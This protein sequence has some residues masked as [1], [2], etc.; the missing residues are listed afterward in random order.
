M[1]SCGKIRP[2]PRVIETPSGLRAAIRVPGDRTTDAAAPGARLVEYRHRDRS[3]MSPLPL[4][5]CLAKPF[6]GRA[7]R[8]SSIPLRRVGAA[9]L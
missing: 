9:T 7:E 6:K 8:P 5:Q 4:E 2:A 3:K 1:P